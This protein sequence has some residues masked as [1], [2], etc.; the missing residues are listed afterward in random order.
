MYHTTQPVIQVPTT[1][2]LI[3]KYQ[4]L[5]EVISPY[6]ANCAS[7]GTVKDF[8]Q[9][10]PYA[11]SFKLHGL[12]FDVEYKYVVDATGHLQE[13]QPYLSEGPDVLTSTELRK[14]VVYLKHR[15]LENFH[16]A[17]TSAR[18]SI[19]D[20]TQTVIIERIYPAEKLILA[21]K[22][23]Q[24]PKERRFIYQYK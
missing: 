18:T 6:H 7:A 15:K 16:L 14:D 11:C 21:R 2:R 3:A 5:D 19:L 12:E 13:F 20:G 23:A 8:L 17:F 22:D 4:V 1:A 9:S 10:G 24:T